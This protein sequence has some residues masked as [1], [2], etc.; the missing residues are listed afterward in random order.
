MQI[1]KEAKS[2]YYHLIYTVNGKRRKITTKQKKKSDALI[3][4]NQF[5]ADREKEQA[6]KA[7]YLTLDE[8]RKEYVSLLDGNKSKNYVRNVNLSFLQLEKYLKT[9]PILRDI[10]PRDIENFIADTYKRAQIASNLYYRILKTAFNKA[11]LWQYI[12]E[13]PFRFIKEPRIKKNLPLFI[14]DAELDEIVNATAEKYLQD[15]FIFGY[16]TG[17]R[18]GEILNLQWNSINLEERTIIIK[19]TK[20]FT[21]KSKKERLIPINNTVYN[22]LI[23]RIP[24]IMGLERN[25]YI[26]TRKYG[27]KLNEDFVSKIFKKAVRKAKLNDKIHFHTLRHSTASKLVQKGASLYVVKEILGHEDIKTTQIYSHLSKDS[28]VKAMALL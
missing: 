21:T 25:E 17:A 13:N 4:L 3:F 18:L 2:D 9:D 10:K 16:N 5:K 22:L 7:R 14:S 19:N 15:L 6:E 24:K 26:F 20:S 8:F 27:I 28:I 1:F 23:N 12:A 11:I